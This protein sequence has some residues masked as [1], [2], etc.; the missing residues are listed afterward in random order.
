MLS[1]P[2]RVPWHGRA[3]E[4]FAPTARIHRWTWRCGGLAAR[5]A[6]AA[7]PGI[8]HDRARALQHAFMAGIVDRQFLE[9]TKAVGIDVSPVGAPDLLRTIEDMSRAPPETF[10]YV[11]RLLAA[12]GG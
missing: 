8:P 12:G 11:R 5:G 3:D 10:D 6:G 4:D 1:C 2:D 9:E 7:L